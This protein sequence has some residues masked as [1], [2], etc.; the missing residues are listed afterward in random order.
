MKKLW[1]VLLLSIVTT[2]LVAQVNLVP[3][4][5]F[6]DTVICPD[7]A[8]QIDRALGWSAYRIS[9]DYYNTCD[10]NPYFGVPSNY[11]GG[12]QYPATGNAYAGLVAYGNNQTFH[13]I[14]G[15]QLLQSLQIGH[16]YYASIKISRGSGY[17]NQ[18]CAG[19]NKLGIKFTMQSYD[20]LTN[21]IPLDNIAQVYTDSIIMDTI[22]WVT[23]G[24]YFCADSNYQYVSFGNFF[25]D[26]YTSTAGNCTTPVWGAYY[27]ID[28]VQVIEDTL[29]SVAAVQGINLKPAVKVYPN[30]S[31]NK[32]IIESSYPDKLTIKMFNQVGQVI[33][34]DYLLKEKIEFDTSEIPNG[35]YLIQIS[36]SNITINKTI[37]I[38]H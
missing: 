30:P 1:S 33:R 8:S 11:Y 17:S 7:N 32:F 27:F 15:I 6:E 4:A 20:F 16:R 28:D 18:Y 36:N 13:E 19:C 29:C 2:S 9:P 35:L 24:G 14:I 38:N 23:V 26:I 34:V 10:L 25:E 31:S 37:L 3:N 22:S 21:Q 12:F 5:S